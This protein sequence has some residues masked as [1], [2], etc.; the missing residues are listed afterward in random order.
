[1]DTMR[2]CKQCQNPLPENAPEGLCPVCLA[3]IAL[4]SEPAANPA[5]K[6]P[7]GEPASTLTIGP[8]AFVRVRY[9]GDYELL[10]E[11]ARGGMGVVWKARQASLN[12]TVALKMILA[13]KLAGEAEVQRFR[14]EAEAA[15]NLQH[16]NIVAIHEVGEHEG[17]HYY[18]MDYVEGRD[19]A[20]LVRETGPLPPAR[21]AECLKTIAEAVHSRT[22]A[23]RFT[24]T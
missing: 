10:E 4:G 17:Q 19:L 3:R 5:A 16:P 11:I 7:T 15:A 18:S 21:A 8:E 1:M 24:E 22:S 23:A 2:I 14:R 13:G 12:R 6:G 20:A 9:F